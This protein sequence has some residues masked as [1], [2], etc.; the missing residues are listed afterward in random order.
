MHLVGVHRSIIVVPALQLLASS[1]LAK[2][3]RL[4]DSLPPSFCLPQPLPVCSSA[5]ERLCHAGIHWNTR[6]ASSMPSHA[7]M[8]M[9]RRGIV[10]PCR[11]V[12]IR[13]HVMWARRPCMP[14]VASNLAP[15]PHPP[16][17][18]R[19]CAA[20]RRPPA[21]RAPPPPKATRARYADRSTA[22]RPAGRL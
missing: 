22:R 3:S 1:W 18:R 14:L 19:T 20:P 4:S 21:R 11:A 8:H 10:L 7:C 6:N 9:D 2:S 13:C 15:K 16:W 5:P 12:R 17:T